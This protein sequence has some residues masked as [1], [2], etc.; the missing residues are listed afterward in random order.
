M[1]YWLKKRFWGLV[2]WKTKVI[3]VTL[4]LQSMTSHHNTDFL[5]LSKY[6][7]VNTKENNQ[8]P[9]DDSKMIDDFISKADKEYAYMRKEIMNFFANKENT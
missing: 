3:D 7:R 4:N 5:G 1:K 2:G 6:L 9:M 8:L